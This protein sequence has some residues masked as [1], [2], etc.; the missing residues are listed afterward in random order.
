M[1]KNASDGK[2]E[3]FLHRPIAG[4]L[5][6]TAFPRG[7]GGFRSFRLKHFCK[8]QKVRSK[9]SDRACWSKNLTATLPVQ[10]K[11]LPAHTKWSALRKKKLINGRLC[12]CYSISGYVT[13]RCIAAKSDRRFFDITWCITTM[14]LF[15]A[16][17]VVPRCIH[18]ATAAPLTGSDYFGKIFPEPRPIPCTGTN[19]T[20]LYSP[21]ASQNITPLMVVFLIFGGG[22]GALGHCIQIDNFQN[23]I[24]VACQN[25]LPHHSWI[26]LC[27]DIEVDWLGSLL[28]PYKFFLCFSLGSDTKPYAGG[29]K[30]QTRP[31]K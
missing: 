14:V 9:K 29:R 15:L 31:Q 27:V 24:N 28:R 4:S 21:Y 7:P 25:T 26:N 18:W 11:N 30:K 16:R 12:T 10:E 5:T 8:Q 22:G 1:L 17:V 3:D 2:S 23:Y 6:W 13:H 20:Y 19:I